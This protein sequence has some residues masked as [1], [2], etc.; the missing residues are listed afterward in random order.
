MERLMDVL[1]TMRNVP[2]D[3]ATQKIMCEVEGWCGNAGMRDDASI[4]ACQ[5][6][7]DEK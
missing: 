1:D 4:L 3:E 2:L 6:G 5:I 7:S